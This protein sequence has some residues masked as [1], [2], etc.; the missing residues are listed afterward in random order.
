MKKSLPLINYAPWSPSKADLASRCP[1]AFKYRYI[2]KIKPEVRNTYAKK[3][4]VIHKAQELVLDG[5]PAKLAFDQ[6][7]EE[8][9][10]L[11][12]SEIEEVKTFIDPV[13]AFKKR[14][15][16]F[17]N[18]NPVKEIRNECEWAITPDF[19][20]CDFFSPDVMIRGIVDFALLLED[21]HLIIIDHKSGKVKPLSNFATQ[22]N[23]YTVMGKVFY[24]HVK[25]IQCA[26]HFVAKE[27]IVWAEMRKPQYVESVLKPWIKEYLNDK[28]LGVEGFNARLG[29][30]CGFCDYK[31]TCP[32]YQAE[33]E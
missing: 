7:I 28:A 8:E 23:I 33:N 14:I 6:A 11:T 26:I 24:P 18:N 20:P 30:H 19:E 1:L 9:K 21:D 13:V 15:D 29:W 16:A 27:K 4:T 10:E 5:K 22:L 31:E 17:T 2:D 32:S 3:G 12:T 25:G